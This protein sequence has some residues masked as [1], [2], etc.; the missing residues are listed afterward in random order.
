[1]LQDQVTARLTSRLLSWGL[2]FFYFLTS[3][4]FYLRTYDSAQVKITIVQMFGFFLVGLFYVTLVSRWRVNWSRFGPFAIPLF[5]SFVSGVMAWVH[6]AY[7]GNSLD[8]TLRRVVYVHLALIAL[9][10]INTLERMRRMVKF[11][12]A[13]TAVA[14]IYGLLQHLDYRFY[15]APMQ[16]WLD[17]FIW[18]QAFSNRVFST[19]GNPNFFGNFLVIV[20]PITLALLLRRNREHPF[21]VMLYAAG[22][23]LLSAFLWQS[24]EL[25]TRIGAPQWETPVFMMLLLGNLFFA[26]VRF[27]VLGPLFFLITLGIFFTFSKG[28]WVG[29]AGSFIS[30][31]LLVLFYFSQFRSDKTRRAILGAVAT[32]LLLVVVAVGYYSKDRPDSIRF[33]LVTWT[34]T[35]EMAQEDPLFGLGV[36]SFRVIYPAFRRP[37][38]FHIEGKHNT[39][40]D[41]AENEYLEVL[42]D[43]GMVGLGIFIWLITL[44]SVSGLRAL[45]RFSAGLSVK[46]VETGKRK[47]SDDP[48]AY[49]M[50]GFLAAFWGMLMHNF[51]DVSLRFVSSGIFLWLLMGLIGALVVHDPMAETDEQYEAREEKLPPPTEGP[52]IFSIVMASAT[53][54]VFA[55]L[56]WKVLSDFN[57]AQERMPPGSGEALLWTIAWVAFLGTVGWA[58]YALYRLCR[59]IRHG[60]TFFILLAL[61]YPLMVFWGYF[62]ADVNHNRGIMYSK[63]GQWAEALRHYQ[64]VIDLNPEYLMAYYFMGNVY[65][66]RWQPGDFDRAM[67]SYRKLWKLA[68][69]YVQSHHQAGLVHLKKAQDDRNQWMQLRNSGRTA[70]AAAALDQLKKDW[71]EA[72]RYFR[73]YHMIDPVFEGNFARAAWVHIQL[74]E[75]AAFEHD[76]AEMNKQYDAAEAQYKEAVEAWGCRLPEHDIMGEHW[77]KNHN[78]YKRPY[79]SEMFENLGNVRMMRG[80]FQ[81]AIEAYGQA[82][83]SD[84]KNVRAL[85]ALAS[86][87]ARAGRRPEF[88][89]TLSRIHEIA[90]NDPDVQRM[91]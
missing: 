36:G 24:G 50:L 48:R 63:Q 21:S 84:P 19:F 42:M 64:K 47:V 40:T 43:E 87:Y 25:F 31:L 11:L 33:R 70:E 73:E 68:P 34:S 54:V 38:I 79:A 35:W 59:S 71:H 27:S 65:T 61:V 41:H 23:V 39:E 90:P 2:P 85:K 37:Q 91:R 3:I 75:I 8:E 45:G 53:A 58:L 80:N 88:N 32:T 17:P 29:F 60:L 86:A 77:E 51:M 69:N 76:S 13:A 44:F 14:S 72:L 89:A 83:E 10:E 81:G 82:A 1:M 18:R 66:D 22:T 5:V 12:L 9:F 55:W 16:G 74:A 6:S 52:S 57:N 56:A 46:D 15:R 62:M 49:Y 26:A 7:P 78:H 28:A 4:A 67:E 30:F 20:T